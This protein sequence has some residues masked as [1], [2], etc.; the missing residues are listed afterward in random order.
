M[1]WLDDKPRLRAA[2]LGKMRSDEAQD[3]SDAEIERCLGNC[4]AG[5]WLVR[6]VK[7]LRAS[8]EITLVDIDVAEPGTQAELFV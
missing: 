3:L 6:L 2:A 1:N 8:G 4:T 7:E 5:M